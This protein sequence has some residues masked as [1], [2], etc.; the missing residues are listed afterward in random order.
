[1]LNEQNDCDGSL[2]KLLQSYKTDDD[3]G[4]GK[5]FGLMGE[6]EFVIIKT[7]RLESRVMN[8]IIFSF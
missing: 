1:M 2:M 8:R 6:I 7:L 4:E 3:E 5:K